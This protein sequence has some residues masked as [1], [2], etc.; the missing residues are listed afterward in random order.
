LQK[1]L[2]NNYKLVK[3][4]AKNANAELSSKCIDFD[5]SS[6]HFDLFV[7]LKSTG[8]D[9]I[10]L[11]I[12]FTKPF[13]KRKNWK[14]LTG[15]SISEK[16]IILRQETN[17]PN[18]KTT[19]SIVGA[20]PG[21]ATVI[22]LSNGGQTLSDC[23]GHTLAAIMHKLERKKKGSKSF[24]KTQQH[25]ENYIN[26]SINQLDF[27]GVKEIRLETNGFRGEKRSRFLSHY[28]HASVEK[29]MTSLAEESGVRL[30][31]RPS[32]YKSQRCCQCGFVCKAN[33]KGKS[34]EC[35]QCYM[36]LDADI[37]SAVNN[38]IDL[39]LVPQW[40]VSDKLNRNGF[41]WKET[42]L[43]DLLGQELKVPDPG[44]DKLL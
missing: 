12:K 1:L 43:F 42:G 37:N 16:R 38:S 3:P 23:H 11:P 21:A 7:R 22:S 2:E 19:G 13:N 27:S 14:L 8:F 36:T 31:L 29:K 25:R 17:T 41:F 4:N 20:D 34:F 28:N 40:V 6:N 32:V 15:V 5:T 39:P 44:K 26:W 33:R 35:K 10:K 24:K 18:I 9:H 30:T